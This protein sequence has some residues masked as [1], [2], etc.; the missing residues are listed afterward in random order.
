[1]WDFEGIFKDKEEGLLSRTTRVRIVD[2]NI[3]LSPGIMGYFHEYFPKTMR[4]RIF[5]F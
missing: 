1:M 3:F 4:G 5:C 2:F